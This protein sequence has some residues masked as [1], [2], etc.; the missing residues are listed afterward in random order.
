MSHYN[1]LRTE[2]RKLRQETVLT[3]Q[4]YMQKF[5]SDENWEAIGNQDNHD[6][7]QGDDYEDF[8]ID[9]EDQLEDVSQ[10]VLKQHLRSGERTDMQTV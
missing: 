5:R 4:K 10:W 6:D 9:E 7:C 3:E 1:Q 8:V 2:I